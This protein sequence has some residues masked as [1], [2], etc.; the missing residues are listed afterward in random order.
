MKDMSQFQNGMGFYGDMPESLNMVV[1]T[2]H[3]LVKEV[4]KTKE[5][6]MDE[7]LKPMQE[8]I[9]AKKS[10][11]EKLEAAKKGKKWD[12]IPQEEKD[13]MD[14]VRKELS[15]LEES[16]RNR[17]KEFGRNNKLAKQLVDLALLANGLL[18]GADLDKFVKRS[19]ELI[20][21]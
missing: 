15:E 2:A 8:E 5:E 19:V 4:L 10:E 17:I 20:Q 7:T 13:M 9:K 3:P 21:K 12:D 11:E 18:K 14:A 6:E 16:K 1:N